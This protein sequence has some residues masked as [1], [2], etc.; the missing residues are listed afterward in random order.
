MLKSFM[1]M[2][3]DLQVGVIVKTIVNN[4]KPEREGE[5]RKISRVQTNAIAF[6]NPLNNQESWLWFGKASNYEYDGKTFKVFDDN[7]ELLFEYEIIGEIGNG[8][9]NY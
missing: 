1:Q 4:I 2:R 9:T 6:K 5:V 7:K 8:T 3:R